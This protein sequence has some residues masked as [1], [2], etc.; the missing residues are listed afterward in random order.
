[1]GSAGMILKCPVQEKMHNGSL[2]VEEFGSRNM[3][4]S[5]QL[6]R[7]NFRGLLFYKRNGMFLFLL[8]NMQT[9]SGLETQ[10]AHQPFFQTNKNIMS[11]CV[12]LSPSPPPKKIT[13]FSEFH[14]YKS[15]ETIK[16]TWYFMYSIK[17][18][19]TLP[20]R[21]RKHKGGGTMNRRAR[22]V[23]EWL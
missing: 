12:G 4:G 2:G 6:L 3:R 1:M 8:R 7:D 15:W 11:H 20:L 16:N 9:R 18:N 19:I 13:E 14:L 22:R 17:W 10:L 21:L 23:G 5:K